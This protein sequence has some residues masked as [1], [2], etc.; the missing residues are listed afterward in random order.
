MWSSAVSP[1]SCAAA[2]PV[3]G[4]WRPRPPNFQ[5]EVRLMTSKI[6][7]GA[8]IVLSLGGCSLAPDFMKPETPVPENWS[9][10]RLAAAEKISTDW[11]RSFDDPGSEEHTS[12]L[13]SLMRISYAVLC[14]KKKH[15]I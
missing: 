6:L 3:T 1:N 14:L 10:A 2:Y 8:V 11:W 5:T 13:Q 12:E 15:Q 9:S 4:F 7:L